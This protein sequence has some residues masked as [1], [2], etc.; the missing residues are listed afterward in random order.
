MTDQWTERLSEYLDGDLTEAEGRALETHLA[1][2]GD[3]AATLE[4][5]RGVV[6]RA[7]SLDDRPPA[8]DLWEGIAQ[9]IGAHPAVRPILSAPGGRR[10]L[11]AR[12]FSVSMPQLAAAAVALI[13]LSGAAMA[14]LLS[15][16]ARPVVAPLATSSDRA[17]TDL[18]MAANFGGAKYDSTVAE[19]ERALT[20][21]RNRLDTATV[22]IVEQNLTI[23]DRAIDQARRALASD[24][25]STYLNDHLAGTLKRKVELL[26]RVTALTAV[27][28]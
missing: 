13:V 2:C 4:A 1:G 26:R 5:L 18:I 15:Y 20:R 7:R 10:A 22:R 23:I 19:L 8:R 9:R 21:N 17:K 27:E 3:C 16:R 25:G 28:S 12:R 11:L 24:P 6:V 14:G